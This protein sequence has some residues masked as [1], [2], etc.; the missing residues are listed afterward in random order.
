[1]LSFF[2]NFFHLTYCTFQL[3]NLFD[4]FLSSLPLCWYSVQWCIFLILSFSSAVV[5]CFLVFKITWLKSLSSKSNIWVSSKT[6]L[7]D[8]FFY[9]VCHTLLL[10]CMVHKLFFSF[11]NWQFN[12]ETLEIRFLPTPWFIIVCSCCSLF[13]DFPDLIL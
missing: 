10:P 9:Y 13:R 3:Q 12:V 5:F 1:M 6:F 11:L 2:S 4:S 7:S 8:C